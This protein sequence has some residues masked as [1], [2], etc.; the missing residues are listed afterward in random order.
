[1]SSQQVVGA[2]EAIYKTFGPLPV[3]KKSYLVLMSPRSGS[4]LLCAHLQQIEYGNPI[5]AFHNN[6]DRIRRTHQWDIDF[7]NPYIY[8]KKALEFQT[9]N[10]IFGMKLDWAQFEV[11]LRTAR[12]LTDPAGL[13]LSEAD[14]VDVFF[15]DALYILLKR[16]NKVKQ[17]VSFA[18]AMQ[19]GI[20]HIDANQDDSVRAYSSPAVYNHDH[21][22]CCLDIL[23][24]FDAAWENY[25]RKFE[26][27]TLE[28][29]Y[30]DLAKDFPGKMRDVYAFLGIENQ[31]V[32]EPRLRKTSNAASEEWVKRFTEET[33][34]LKDKAISTALNSGDLY[35][36]F[37]W[38]MQTLTRKTER[39]N[40]RRIPV[41]RPV[42]KP[43]WR[44]WVRA[45]RKLGL[46]KN[47]G[48]RP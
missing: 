5:E 7:S 48:E 31:E 15:P 44:L 12:Q 19:D 37:I 8:V 9:V 6:T 46:N 35:T 39:E 47:R 16:R 40:W 26:L 45:R 11:F 33:P 18:R 41:N 30:E 3:P 32:P 43:I 10:G 17:A 22:E 27:P 24:S 29:W 23:L 4:E 34:W 20:W 38:R 36:A 2:R 21:I 1:M 13:P 42:L 28:L 14:I 25:L